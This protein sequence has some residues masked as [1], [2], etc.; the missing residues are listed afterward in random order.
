MKGAKSKLF[1]NRHINNGIGFLYL[2]GQR[3]VGQTHIWLSGET[4][5]SS[6]VEQLN[7]EIETLR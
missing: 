2:F 5:Y 4:L 7:R 1:T 6:K 3:S